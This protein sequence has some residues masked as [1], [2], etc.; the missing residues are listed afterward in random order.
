MARQ[1]QGGAALETLA[2]YGVHFMKASQVKFGPQSSPENPERSS[3]CGAVEMNR[4]S[5]HE[6][7]GSLP[8]FARWVKD[9]VLLRAVV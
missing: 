4:T 8:G 6:D 5:I 2:E 9:P 1:G 3:C 7:E